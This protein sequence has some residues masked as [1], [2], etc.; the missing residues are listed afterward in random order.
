[1]EKF[2][3]LTIH[4]EGLHSDFLWERI[5]KILKFFQKFNIKATW[6]SINPTFIGYKFEEKKWIERLNFLKKSGQEIQ[7]HTH[8]YKGKEGIFKGEGYDLAKENIQKRILED[9]NWLKNKIEIEPKGFV[10]GAFKINDEVLEILEKE[11]Y[12]YDLSKREGNIFNSK[13]L[14]E[15][16][17]LSPL[18]L[19]LI[20]PKFINLKNLR[21]STIYF[22]DYDLEK[23]LFPNL[24]RFLILFYN[25]LGFK[26]ISVNSLY[27][28]IRNI[29][30]SSGS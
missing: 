3:S 14:I 28:K 15:I 25:F 29:N 4:T 30:L 23:F 7:Q 5:E 22:H 10:S 1:M 24:L 13:N 12:R 21:F 17:T 2:I 16:P 9:K 6:F 27:E 11:G 19:F 18:K 26:F 20:K 8:F